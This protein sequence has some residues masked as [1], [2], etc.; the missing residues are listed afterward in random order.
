MSLLVSEIDNSKETCL[1]KPHNLGEELPVET[2]I[3]WVFLS[4]FHV[5]D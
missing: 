5:V 1:L 2:D 4:G 3:T